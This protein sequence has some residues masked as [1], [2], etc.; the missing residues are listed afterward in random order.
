MGRHYHYRPGSFYRQDDR[1]GFPQRAER[2]RTQWN[3]IIVDESLWEPRQP[4][5]LV[6]G[7]KDDQ[8]VP[9]ARP[10]PPNHFDGPIYAQITEDVGV[11]ALFIPL[12]STQ[13]LTVGDQIGVMLNADGGV[14]FITGISSIVPGGIKVVD[15][16]PGSVASGNLIVDY[17]IPY[18]PNHQTGFI[19]TEDHDF[20]T[21]ESGQRLIRTG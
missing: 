2:T 16:L 9:Y 18:T 20:L 6:R 17:L 11:G 15:V 4:Q 21:T 14:L 13:G 8:T 5:D 12:A 7:V 19:L 1:S 10:L 3:N